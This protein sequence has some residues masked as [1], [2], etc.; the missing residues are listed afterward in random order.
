MDEATRTRIFEP[1]FTT[2]GVGKGTG[3]GL[4]TTYGIVQQTGGTISVH[5]E[6]GVGTTFEIFFPR[7]SQSPGLRATSLV[8]PPS[9]EGDETILLVEDDDQVRSV[10]K[11]ILRRR[12]YS[13][14]EGR[15]GAEALLISEQ[16]AGRIDALITDVVM[17]LMNG[18][19]L[20]ERLSI[21]RPSMRVLFMSGYTDN[22]VLSPTPESGI[23]LLPKP[24]TPDTLLRKL[25]TVL[26][27]A[28]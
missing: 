22:V 5:S 16:H 24:I 20:A 21:S 28:A 13:V 11:T 25:R 7:S 18:K 10:V 4:S 14:L 12:G 3:L 26:S 23:E 27:G 2:K 8:A 9:L 15:N 17:P 6:P 19:Q 1:F